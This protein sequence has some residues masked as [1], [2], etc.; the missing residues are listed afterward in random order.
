M[1]TLFTCGH[2]KMDICNEKTRA[3]ADS[4]RCYERGT[5]A[6]KVRA[7]AGMLAECP[8]EQVFFDIRGGREEDNGLSGGW[9]GTR[10][11]TVKGAGGEPGL[12]VEG[13]EGCGGQS[14]APRHVPPH[15][16]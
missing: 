14:T 3:E 16:L 11:R 15:G 10:G 6:G 4:L 9:A 5:D 13:Q 7:R 8:A 12:E 2:W 1:K